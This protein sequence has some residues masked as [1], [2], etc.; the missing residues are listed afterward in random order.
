VVESYSK[1]DGAVAIAGG[2]GI[3][4][5]TNIGGNLRVNSIVESNS[6]LSG[7]VV[8]SGGVGVY[9]NVYVGGNINVP[10]IQTNTI[11][12]SPPVNGNLYIGQ[13][14]NTIF[15][16]NALSNLN[17]T[18]V[19]LGGKYDI[20][21]ITG[22]LVIT[23]NVIQKNPTLLST[24]YILI[25]ALNQSGSSNGTSTNN[26]LDGAG[27]FIYDGSTPLITSYAAGFIKI[28]ADAFGYVFQVTSYVNNAG[29]YTYYPNP[30]KLNLKSAFMSMGTTPYYGNV[31][32]NANILSNNNNN[33]IL[34]LQ[35]KPAGVIDCSY[36][37]VSSQFDLSSI[38]QRNVVNSNATVQEI[39][40]NLTIMGTTLVN[41]GAN[42][43]VGIL[44]AMMDVSGN[45]IVSKL[46]IGTNYVNGN[47]AS[48]DIA[49][50]LYQMAGGYIIQF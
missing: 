29:T 34:V 20:I 27:I 2:V 3:Y 6:I 32:L 43:G 33:S 38:V 4:A 25:N 7:A 39:N 44:N 12:A 40:T 22:N 42:Y 31:M 1:S 9:A 18:I 49:G 19:N 37:I 5:N 35:N 45:V 26:Y 15:L 11:N 48:L 30:V 17:S 8:I 24:P 50:N 16:A 46:G 36:Q 47:T 21:N 41:K 10:T 23:G 13:K 28:S 14:S